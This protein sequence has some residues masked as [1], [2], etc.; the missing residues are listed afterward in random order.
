MLGWRHRGCG[1]CSNDARKARAHSRWFEGRV[2][3]ATRIEA[4][5]GGRNAVN[6]GVKSHATGER[7][8]QSLFVNSED[9]TSPQ[10]GLKAWW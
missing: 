8:M 1:D 10:R 6:V 9:Y 4:D 5:S 2:K 3:N 7:C